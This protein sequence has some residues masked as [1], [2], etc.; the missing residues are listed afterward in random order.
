MVDAYGYVN[1]YVDEVY[2]VFV[3]FESEG[4]A[5]ALS[6]VKEGVEADFVVDE[7]GVDVEA[8]VYFL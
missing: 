3:V 5:F 2:T 8:R 6:G 1:Y 4:Y 7:G